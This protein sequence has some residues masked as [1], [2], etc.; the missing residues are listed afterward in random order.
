MN[1]KKIKSYPIIS[2]LLIY[3]LL[4]SNLFFDGI[5][6]NYRFSNYSLYKYGNLLIKFFT[7]LGFLWSFLYPFILWQSDKEK[8]KEN[9]WLII[10]ISIPAIYFMIGLFFY[11][12]KN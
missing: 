7:Y 6:S 3:L 5:F 8:F 11:M 9:K 1:L 4:I 12:F 2:L 10:V